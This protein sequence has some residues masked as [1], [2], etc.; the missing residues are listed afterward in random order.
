MASP[1][2]LLLP[3]TLVWALVL[4]G[5]T[6]GAGPEGP[7]EAQVRYRESSSETGGS[8]LGTIALLSSVCATWLFVFYA[9]HCLCASK[10][11]CSQGLEGDCDLRWKGGQAACGE[12]EENHLAASQELACTRT[13]GTS[14]KPVCSQ[15][16]Q[17]YARQLACMEQEL[18][19]FLSEVRNRRNALG[20]IVVEE[21]C[22]QNTERGQDKLRITVY[23][24]SDTEGAGQ[25]QQR[26]RRRKMQLSY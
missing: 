23:E 19:G 2:E 9:I 25:P 13:R 18:E 8:W 5:G 1:R 16:Q 15:A 10:D 4:L 20:D 22:P 14:R 26:G 6:K 17:A 12:G 24:I 7:C 11:R 3:L 21:R